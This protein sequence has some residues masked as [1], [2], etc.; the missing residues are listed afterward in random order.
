MLHTPTQLWACDTDDVTALEL[1]LE[2]STA[3]VVLWSR[4]ALFSKWHR[5]EVKMARYI[6]LYQAIV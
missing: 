3:T 1:H 5:A 6:E 2:K 4:A